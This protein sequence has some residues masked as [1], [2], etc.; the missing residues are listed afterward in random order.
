MQRG[1]VE[2]A[3][4]SGGSTATSCGSAAQCACVVGRFLSR[5][6]H[7][8]RKNLPHHADVDTLADDFPGQVLLFPTK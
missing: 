8:G 5:R 6:R 4:Q 3:V 2:G 7:V 1:A